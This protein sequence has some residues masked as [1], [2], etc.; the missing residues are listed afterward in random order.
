VKISEAKLRFEEKYFNYAEIRKNPGNISEYVVWLYSR[1]G[2]SFMLCYE[3]SSAVSSHE[4][5]HLVPLLRE[6]G[7]RRAKVYF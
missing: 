1:D 2:K 4:L 3:N 5:D 7:F 6:V